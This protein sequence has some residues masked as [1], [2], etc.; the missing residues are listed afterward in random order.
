MI[1]L[2]RVERWG[3]NLYLG[4][5]DNASSAERVNTT[6]EAGLFAWG[7]PQLRARQFYFKAVEFGFVFIALP[8][9]ALSMGGGLTLPLV[10]NV[11]LVSTVILLSLT[12][13][14]HW[15]DLLPVDFWSEG[16]LLLA[17]V[18]GFALA[19]FLLTLAIA[20]EQLLSPAPESI[21][22]LIA[23]PFVTALPLELVYRA[24]FF[25][26][27]GRLF[28]SER[29]SIFVGAGVTA[30]AYAVLSHSAGGA[31][32]GFGV[33]AVLGAAYLRTGNFLFCILLH[34]AAIAS[35][36]LIGPGLL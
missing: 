14:F 2:L 12:Q 16:R 10:M 25:R 26:R 8:L 18:A 36:Y 1:A 35:L 30:L 24:L 23:F 29:A 21:A 32:V 33:G 17:G 31:L 5:I 19:A 4:P 3:S 11:M 22:M 15:R 28:Q 13:S 34:W 6:D 27:Y 9:V 7:L 20:P